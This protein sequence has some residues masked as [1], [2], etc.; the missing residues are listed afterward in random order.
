[1]HNASLTTLIIY[2]LAACTVIMSLVW[3]WSY[4][5]KNAGVVD[6]FWSYN[7]P[8]IAVILYLFAPGFRLVSGSGDF[9]VRFPGFQESHIDRL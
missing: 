8:V 6:I 1:M 4:R 2:S 9:G 3:V 5:I 7:F